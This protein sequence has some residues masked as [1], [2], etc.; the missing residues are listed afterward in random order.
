M[1]DIWNLAFQM[2]L[3]F[4]TIRIT[5]L[6]YHKFNRPVYAY[7]LPNLYITYANIF[8]SVPRKLRKLLAH[9]ADQRCICVAQLFKNSPTARLCR[10]DRYNGVI[11]THK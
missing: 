2:F 5:L 9:Y 1:L 8:N 6:R 3:I 10:V 4:Q 11:N 7:Q